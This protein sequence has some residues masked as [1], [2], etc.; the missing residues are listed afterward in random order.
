M[1]PNIVVDPV[2]HEP[3]ILAEPTSFGENHYYHVAEEGH[4]THTIVEHSTDSH[5]IAGK[6]QITIT[7]SQP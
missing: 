3:V 1:T 4:V 7:D 6:S 2:Y 5:V